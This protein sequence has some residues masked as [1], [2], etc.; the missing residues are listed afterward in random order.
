M[1]AFYRPDNKHGASACST[2]QKIT[3]VFM[4]TFGIMMFWNC[5]VRRFESIGENLTCNGQVQ[6]VKSQW[7]LIIGVTRQQHV[8]CDAG[9]MTPLPTMGGGVKSMEVWLL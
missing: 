1:G 4:Y 9:T 2:V 3:H 5:A 8:E 6:M 7:S